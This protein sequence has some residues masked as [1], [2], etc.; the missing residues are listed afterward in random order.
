MK[1]RAAFLSFFAFGLCR[2]LCATPAETNPSSHEAKSFR[3]RL[4]VHSGG[5][6][7]YNKPVEVAFDPVALSR[8]AGLSTQPKWSVVQLE[9]VDRTGRVLV[10]DIPFQY[11]EIPRPPEI[12]TA[13][14]A[15][16]FLLKGQTPAGSERFFNLYCAPVQDLPRKPFAPSPVSVELLADYQGEPTYKINTPA[17]TYYYHRLGGG[18]ASLI[19]RDGNDWISYRPSGGFEGDFRGI[20]NI[21]PPD[22]HP[23]RGQNHRESVLL[24]SG[25]LRATVVSETRDGQWACLW[26]I[27]PAHARMT[28]FRKG[29]APYWIL[30]EGTPGGRFDAEEDYWVNSAGQRFPVAPYAE[31]NIWHGQ[32]PDPQWVYFG[33]TKLKRVLFLA[34]HE[35]DTALDEF[36]HRGSGG[37]TVFGFGRGP[38]KDG[39]QRMTTLPVHLTLGLLETDGFAEASA[40][41]HSAFRQLSVT[42]GPA[43]L[44]GNTGGTK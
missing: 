28:L 17:A 11:D 18:F 30:Y 27:F 40:Q 9:E 35:P 13:P 10:A 42:I 7:R 8:Q 21:A 43:V 20:P 32:L 5:C 26:D 2:F 4:A 38:R 29:A 22:F 41:I 3:L 19:D 31:K 24:S 6:V 16:V 15:L 33:D 14:V 44:V 37:M 36:W 25:P 39:W 1:S 23:G 12:S 34:V